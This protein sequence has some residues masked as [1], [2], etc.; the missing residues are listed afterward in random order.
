M[1]AKSK[2]KHGVGTLTNRVT[3]RTFVIIIGLHIL[4]VNVFTFNI[5]HRE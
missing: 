3:T 2:L 4:W 5:R 1:A